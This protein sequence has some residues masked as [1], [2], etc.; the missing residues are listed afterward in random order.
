ML[1]LKIAA[2][3]RS[4]IS[5]KLRYPGFRSLAD[6][7]GRQYIAAQQ[8]FWYN[9]PQARRGPIHTSIRTC[10]RVSPGMA[11]RGSVAAINPSL[12]SFS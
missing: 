6:R 11:D 5:A 2:D 3:L 7:T 10:C 9:A 12:R 1:H 8:L 4:R